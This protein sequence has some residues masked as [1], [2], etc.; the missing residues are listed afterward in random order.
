MPFGMGVL[1]PAPVLRRE[2]RVPIEV[3]VRIAGNL[4]LPG[5]ET[6]FTD[7]VS[8]T[9][10]R[11]F[12][13]RPWKTNDRLTIATVTGSFRSVARVAYCQV[14]PESGYAVGLEFINPSGNWV[15]GQSGASRLM[16][17]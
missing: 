14:V 1:K 16:R 12:S 4:D 13:V 8:S 9:G 2:T 7:N 3:A 10:A 11:V 17:A 15:V 6:T 5:T